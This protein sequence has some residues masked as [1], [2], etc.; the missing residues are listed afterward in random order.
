MASHPHYQRYDISDVPVHTTRGAAGTI[1][2]AKTLTRPERGVAPAP[3]ITAPATLLPSPSGTLRPHGVDPADSWDAWRIFSRV[4]TF[5]A[6]GVL[7]KSIGGLKDKPTQQAWRE[8][9]AL[10]SIV[11]FMGALVGF[12]TV[13]MQRVLCPADSQDNISRYS[14]KGSVE[15]SLGIQG[16]EVI[17]MPT[18]PTS[19][20]DFFQLAQDAGQ[21]ITPYFNRQASDFPACSG[22]IYR[23]AQDPPCNSQT[24][25]PL[26]TINSTTLNSLGLNTSS[27]IVGYDWGQVAD[28][29]NFFVIDG[30]VLNMDPYMSLHP[31]PI[32]GDAVDAALRV[33]LRTQSGA[34]GRDG[35]RVFYSR[36]D[37]KVAV[38]CLQQ[39][40]FAGNI[41]KIPPGCFASQLFLY[42]GLVVVLGLVLARF[43][44]AC[45]FSWFM[46]A[47][48]AGPPE[49]FNWSR[50]AISPAVLP[51]GAN[52]AIDNKNG[53]AP[54]AGGNRST[55][56]ILNKQAKSF[57]SSSTS[58]LVGSENGVS[59]TISLAQIGAELFAVCLVTCYSEGE[60]SL[61][62]TL[63]SIS[64]TTYADSRKLL[65]VVADGMITGHGEKRSTPDICVSLLDADP[66]FG[67]PMPMSYV[68]VGSGAKKENRA[69]VYAGHYSE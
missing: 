61:R 67:N 8:K 31:T 63:D 21:D 18:A 54:W 1:R 40:Y 24:P 12:A 32:N 49:N 30:A 23:I 28:L 20:V 13:G 7:L 10:C 53:T 26:P 69:M 62:T 64:K 3:L 59:P 19:P 41:D 25:C 55:N 4:I 60:D 65:F 29:P 14:S 2:R 34:S 48:L 15:N 36:S 68:A 46:S 5:W 16:N 38:P 22:L 33:L 27:L 39:R 66:R 42:A 11:L 37:I 56:K 47:R 45:V 17:V 50:S 52:V 44:M 58:T 9:I 43:A 35:T 57:A 51:E 6:P